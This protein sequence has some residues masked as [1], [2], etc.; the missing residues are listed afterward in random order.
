MFISMLMFYRHLATGNSVRTI[1]F[2]YRMGESTV[3][4]SIKD[5]CAAINRRMMDTHLSRPTE[6]EW[7]NI[8]SKLATRW[9]FPNCIGAIDGKHILLVAPPHSGSIFF[10][11]GCG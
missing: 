2:N 6:Q 7:R 5:A 9:N 1:A 8:A 11:V 4:K 3:V 10:S